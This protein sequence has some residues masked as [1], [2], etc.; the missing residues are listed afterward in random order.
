MN[1]RTFLGNSL[2]SAAALSIP[3]IRTV[4]AP[5]AANDRISVAYVGVGGHGYN[6]VRSNLK[7]HTCG[8]CD[9]DD[10]YAA[11]AY[12]KFPKVPRYLDFRKMF[13]ALGSKID[14]VSIATPDHTHFPIAM[15]AMQRGYDVYLEKP[16]AHTIPQIRILRQA[17]K[18][19][20]VKTQLGI[21]GRSMEGTRLIK[22]WLESGVIG[23][24][25]DIYFWTDRPKDRDFHIYETDAPAQPVPNSL[26]WDLFLGP[27]RERRY[28]EIYTPLSW[29]GWWDFGNGGLGDIGT[30]MWDVAEYALEIGLPKTITAKHDRPSEVGMPRWMDIDY[31]FYSKTQSSPVA[32]H[33]NSGFKDGVQNFPTNLPYWPEDMEKRKIAGM[34]FVGERGGIY[35][36]FMRVDSRPYV[37]PESLWNDF[38]GDLPEKKLKRVK[39]G[40]YN[41]FFNAMRENRQPNASFDKTA[42]LSE[43]V[44][45][46]NIAVRTGKTI[47]WDAENAKA[48]GV[49]E[50]DR[51]IQGPTPREGWEYSL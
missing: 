46:G 25:V 33:W 27:A 31:T 32:L 22:E 35:V 37:F 26:D 16:M 28:N 51:Y 4:A 8:F 15:E 12:K 9:V 3:N 5:I 2:A 50:A 21:Q 18:K 45:V 14:A 30:H 39:G 43:S 13:D 7:E 1:R 38:K 48:I 42:E 24:V 36:P 49:P 20:D 41:E 10:V 44:L 40:H 47:Q 29:R 11:K 34:Y 17:A 19:Y 6:A 23:K